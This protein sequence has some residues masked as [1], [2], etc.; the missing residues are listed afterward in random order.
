MDKVLDRSPQLL[1]KSRSRVHNFSTATYSVY[2]SG[3]YSDTLRLR[4]APGKIIASTDIISIYM[5][6]YMVQL[7]MDWLLDLQLVPTPPVKTAPV[8]AVSQLL[9]YS[10]QE[11]TV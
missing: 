7:S 11:D 4:S 1:Q 9:C 10:M 5:C 2:T 6:M 3:G 8:N